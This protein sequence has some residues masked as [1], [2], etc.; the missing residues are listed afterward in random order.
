MHRAEGSHGIVAS[1]Q[2][3]DFA[4][5]LLG[6]GLRDQVAFDLELER[7]LRCSS[8][9]FYKPARFSIRFFAC[10]FKETIASAE[11]LRFQIGGPTLFP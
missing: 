1:E 7:L 2:V 3:L 9:E 10:Q 6:S 8:R 5:D 4:D 11:H